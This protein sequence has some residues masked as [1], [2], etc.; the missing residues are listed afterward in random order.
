[1]L[2]AAVTASED[3]DEPGRLV[4]DERGLAL[5]TPDG[6][7]LLDEVQPAGGRPMTGDA[8]VRGRPSILG[9]VV[10]AERSRGVPGDP[11]VEPA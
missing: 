3:D 7:L 1:M 11:S 6:R 8:L 9:R 2:A 10:A 5:A 4:P